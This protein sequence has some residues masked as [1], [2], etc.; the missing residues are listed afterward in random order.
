VTEQFIDSTM[1]F[2]M[3]KARQKSITLSCSIAQA[4]PR[5]FISD[6]V[7]L[8]QILG[9]LLSNAIKFTPAS[10]AISIQVHYRTRSQATFGQIELPPYSPRDPS[11]PLPP[12]RQPQQELSLVVD[13]D[14]GDDLGGGGGGG[15][16]ELVFSV[17]DTGIGIPKDKFESI[18]HSFTQADSSTTRLYGGTGL[19][20]A[21]SLKLVELLGGKIW[22]DSEEGR[23][24]TFGFF[25]SVTLPTVSE[26]EQANITGDR[27]FSSTIQ[28]NVSKPR[29]IAASTPPC[30]Q[31]QQQ[32]QQQQHQHQEGS[33]SSHA[34]VGIAESPMSPMQ[35]T[36]DPRRTASVLLVEDNAM[37]QKVAARLLS[38]LGHVAVVANNGLEAVNVH[39][40]HHY[41]H[42]YYLY[43]N[44]LIDVMD[45]WTQISKQQRFDVILMDCHMPV[46]DGLEATQQIR[47]DPS[48]CNHAT[49]IVALTANAIESN[50]QLCEQ[51]GMDGFLTKPIRKQ[52]LADAIQE[53]MSAK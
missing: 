48:N 37:N 38:S 51:C 34:L 12:F 50:R 23:G 43:H 39:S 45:R 35:P 3:T 30:A 9:N 25:V 33:N 53:R 32:Q 24:S 7:R 31:Q 27:R 41:H 6:E 17:S 40:N 8:R 14:Q 47:K 15:E 1:A 10:G 52:E 42:H 26:L 46:M 28:K 19:G 11:T 22:V 49:P 29:L 4:T 16:G 5:A 44:S 21:I 36:V 20:L 13:L 2:V 18:F